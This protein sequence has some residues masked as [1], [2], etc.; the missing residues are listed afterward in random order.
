MKNCLF[1]TFIVAICALNCSFSIAQSYDEYITRSFDFIDA[2]SLPQAEEALR[3]ALRLEPGNPGNGMLLLNLG[4]IQ[5]RLGKLKDAED[6]YTIGLAFLPKNLT[7]LN[8]RA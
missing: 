7:L 5:R 8:N 6:S 1:F 4:T 3:E 2:D